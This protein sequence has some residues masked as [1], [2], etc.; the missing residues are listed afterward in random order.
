MLFNF[1]SFQK[2]QKLLT[3]TVILFYNTDTKD[4]ELLLWVRKV[5]D[6]HGCLFA[7]TSYKV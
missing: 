2:S 1:I 5:I 6:Q 7:G 4:L 3:C